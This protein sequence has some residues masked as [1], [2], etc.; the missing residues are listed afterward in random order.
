VS[1]GHDI[2]TVKRDV[3]REPLVSRKRAGRPR[4]TNCG[5][6][7][8]GPCARCARERKLR[9]RAL[10]RKANI[11]RADL[12][13]DALQRRIHSSREYV[14]AYLRRGAIVPSDACDRCECDLRPRMHGD[15]R[16]YRIF[17]PD[18]AKPREVAWLCL[19]C[20]RYENATR[21]PIELLWRWPG[22]AVMRS[23]RRP[24]IA[25]E[26]ATASTFMEQRLPAATPSMRFSAVVGAVIASLALPDRERIFA[27]GALAGRRWTPTGDGDLD[28]RLREWVFAER[29]TR[30]TVARAAGG[31]IVQPVEARTR[32]RRLDAALVPL[33]HERKPFDEEA[34]RQRT[35]EALQ[36]LELADREA[37]AVN[38]RLNE[39]L[40][41]MRRR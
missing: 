12:T 14:R 38:E 35:S 40:A 15:A 17:H 26:L 22:T 5:A 28:A 31:P 29:L 41:R 9:Q 1:A 19:S 4:T 11:K 8:L 37:D 6:I 34:N 16:P 18:P 36:K 23:R 25:S 33:E 39:M 21:D 24:D 27:E 7:H 10:E 30:G 32:K 2:K 20:Y 3:C 13:L